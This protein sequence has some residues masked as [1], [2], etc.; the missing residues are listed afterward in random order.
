[1]RNQILHT[2]C[3]EM[4]RQMSESGTKADLVIADPPFNIGFKYDEYNDKVDSWK[5]LDFSSQWMRAAHENS[6]DTAAMWLFIGDNY[7]AELKV[8]A[9]ALGWELRQWCVWQFS[10][11]VNCKKMFTKS[12]THALHFVKNQKEFV[13]N[14]DCKE[15]RVP[16]KRQQLY[17]DKRA[18]PDGRLPDDVWHYPRIAGTFKERSGFHGCQMPE[19]L[20]ARVIHATSLQG[21][22]VVD[23]FCGSGTTAAVCKK[24]GRQFLTCDTSENYIAGARDRLEKI[25]EYSELCGADEMVV[26]RKEDLKQ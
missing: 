18:S 25:E 8:L 14:S 3:R 2:D 1:M 24:L 13:F 4:F 26:V 12:H 17:N 5:Y 7:A 9:T 21:D 16:S 23:P 10:F 19:K 11:G 20:I 22:L 6:T 15:L